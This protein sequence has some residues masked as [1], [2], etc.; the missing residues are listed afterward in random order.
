[1]NEQ[2]ETVVIGGGQAGLAISYYLTQQGRNHVVLEQAAQVGNRWRNY[3][4]DSF[5]WVTPNWT[6]RLPGAEYQGDDPDGFLTRAEIVACFEQY[7]ER[8]NLPVRYGVRVIAIEQKLEGDG[9]T[10]KTDRVA[11]EAANVVIATGLAQ[12]PRLPSF[13]AEMPTE[14]TQLHSSQYRNSEALP[15]GAVLV[16]G[17]AQSGCQ[18]VE[19]LYQSRRKVYLCV[20]SAVR[21]PRRYRTKDIFWWLN[22]F[23]LLKLKIRLPLP[24]TK[25]PTPPHLSGKDGGHSLN[26][27]QFARDGV[28]LLGHLQSVQGDKIILA[29]DL[30]K[31]LSRAD[32][33]ETIFT[34]LIDLYVLM[35]GMKLPKESLPQLRDGY[36]VKEILELDLKSAEINTV[37]WATGYRFDFSWVKVPILDKHGRPIYKR[38][39]TKSAG[40]YFLGLPWQAKSVVLLGIGDEAAYIASEMAARTQLRLEATK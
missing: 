17:S 29:Q 27:H 1:M 9:Y 19:E 13:A 22:K 32:R 37:I 11:F 28:V 3:C 39:I 36:E 20:G 34:R 10:V 15:A 38:G 14:I 30:K 18:I 8:F 33:A 31:Y 16:V 7:V 5:T 6:I 4:W 2:I 24:K 23:G 25:M 35:T 26:L 12:Q 40:L 21:I